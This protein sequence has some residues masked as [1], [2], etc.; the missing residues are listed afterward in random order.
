M[1]NQLYNYKFWLLFLTFLS[2]YAIIGI[3]LNLLPLFPSTLSKEFITKFNSVITS[4]SY[5]ILSA[6]IF[7]WFT[8]TLPRKINI[9][10]SKKILSKKIH[11]LLYELFIM[12]N[13]ILH[14]YDIKKNIAKIEAKDLIHLDGNEVNNFIGY[15]HVGEYWK[16][17]GP[18]AKNFTGFGDIKFTF[19]ETINATLNKLPDYIND[20]RKTNPN[21]YIDENLTEILASIETN[22]IIKWYGKKDVNLFCY[23]GSYKELYS[24]IVE[25]RKLTKLKYHK[26]FRDS[27]HKIHFYSEEEIR[28]IPY[29]Q[30]DFRIKLQPKLLK[31]KSLRPCLV[32]NPQYDDARAIISTLNE[33]GILT[34][35]IL[36][37]QFLLS[38]Y[39]DEISP[40]IQSDCI[41]II[42]EKISSKKIRRFAKENSNTKIIIWLKAN[43]FYSSKKMIE[44]SIENHH[45]LYQFYYRKPLSILGLSMGKKYPTKNIIDIIS[46]NISEIMRNSK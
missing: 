20:I 12:I 17:D 13:Q 18:K 29:R 30:N 14:T 24:L 8:Y 43:F 41:I 31:A 4:I 23:S 3:D 26:L 42:G 15:Y 22:N 37:K 21:F 36:E 25:Y 1:K 38:Q 5:S 40:P 32:Y 2:I 27:Y 28:Y 10:R 39:I 9:Y 33:G 44:D 19:P 46:F 45:K 34:N 7:Y 6:Y 16:K 11:W 35:G